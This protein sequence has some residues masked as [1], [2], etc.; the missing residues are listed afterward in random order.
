MMANPI[1]DDELEQIRTAILAGRKLDAVRIYKESTGKDLMTSKGDVEALTRELE[2]GGAET[3]AKAARERS[4]VADEPPTPVSQQGGNLVVICFWLVFTLGLT[5][6]A[7]AE[8]WQEVRFRRVAREVDAVVVQGARSK[9]L[10]VHDGERVVNFTNAVYGDTEFNDW[11]VGSPGRIL[12][13]PEFSWPRTRQYSDNEVV[14]H[15]LYLVF[16]GICARV[17]VVG[18][19][20]LSRAAAKE[21]RW[22]VRSRMTFAIGIIITILLVVGV[23]WAGFYLMFREIWR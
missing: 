18:L 16:G 13:H 17:G 14:A 1:S 12:Y 6:G 7:A 15:V 23:W 11:K 4:A 22:D 8:L 20:R 3:F 9:V 2:Q 21:S 19:W 5:L 10:Q